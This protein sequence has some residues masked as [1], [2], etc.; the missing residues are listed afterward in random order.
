MVP[1]LEP[2]SEYKLTVNVFNK[3]G[4]GPKSDPVTFD[5]PEGGEMTQIHTPDDSTLYWAGCINE[6]VAKSYVS[7]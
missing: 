5:T 7:I 3:K 6:T 4:K 2:F 1:G